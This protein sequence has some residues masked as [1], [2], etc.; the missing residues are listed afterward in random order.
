MLPNHRLSTFD[1]KHPSAR[2]QALVLPLFGPLVL[3]PG[4]GLVHVREAIQKRPRPIPADLE[5][6]RLRAKIIGPP[7]LLITPVERRPDGDPLTVENPELEPALERSAAAVLD[8]LPDG[9][10]RPSRRPLPWRRREDVANLAVADLRAALLA[11]KPAGRLQP[12]VERV[13]VDRAM[14]VRPGQTAP[15]V[16]DMEGLTGQALGDCAVFRLRFLDPALG[17]RPIEQAQQLDEELGVGRQGL[18]QPARRPIPCR[19]KAKYRHSRS[20]TW[21]SGT[22]GS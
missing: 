8:R 22:V 13:P 10:R 20:T 18:R 16:Q 17:R 4:V 1:P 7:A 3:V 5:A 12:C 19:N 14:L 21:I 15:F 11:A 2:E 6:A 9:L